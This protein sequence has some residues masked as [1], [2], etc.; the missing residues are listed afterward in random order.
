VLDNHPMLGTGYTPGCVAKIGR[1]PPQR[2]KKPAPLRQAVI[3]RRRP[4]AARTAPAYAAMRLYP[5]LDQLGL[6]LGAMQAH[7][8][9][10]ETDEALH[11]IQNG[12]NLQL[13]G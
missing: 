3:A 13:N 9:V 1:N 7:L 4:L 12:F 5:D 11:T 2:H 6:L 8:A 10:D